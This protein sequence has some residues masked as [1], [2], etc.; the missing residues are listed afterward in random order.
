LGGIQGVF[1]I[2]NG[3][4]R[5]VKWTSVSPGS[6]DSGGGPTT[7]DADADTD[8]FAGMADMDSAFAGM[9]MGGANPASPPP[10]GGSGVK[11]QE[12]D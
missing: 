2:R 7:P 8:A 4:G 10:V 6:K 5:A 1:H 9:G 11:I 3:S 12:V